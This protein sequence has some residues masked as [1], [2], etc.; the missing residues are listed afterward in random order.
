MNTRQGS[1]RAGGFRTLIAALTAAVMLTVPAAAAT[2]TADDV[3]IRNSP[4]DLGQKNSIG[5]LSSGDTVTVLEKTTDASGIE[6]YHIELPN[7]NRGYVKAQ[8]VDNGGEAVKSSEQEQAP[9]AEEAP[10]EDSQEEA[11]PAQDENAADQEAAQEPAQEEGSDDDWTAEDP[12][13]FAAQQEAQAEDGEEAAPAEETGEDQA[14]VSSDQDAPAAGSADL[15][16]PYTDPEAHYTIHFVT[17]ND[18]T[19]NWYIY[20]YDTDKRIRIGDLEQLSDARASAE[21][22]AS[23]AARW[24]TIACIL[25]ILLVVLLLI[26]Y[27]LVKRNSPVRPRRTSASARDRRR[28][29]GRALEEDSEEEDSAEEDSAEDDTADDFDEEESEES[30]SDRAVLEER[31]AS[32]DLAEEG[33]TAGIEPAASLVGKTLRTGSADRKSVV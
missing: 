14:G 24:R 12:E 11:Q 25:L 30:G 18:G 20:N 8:W 33:M 16:D 5:S 3:V 4:E 32:G 7:K 23:A 10:A 27:F 15:Y 2:V 31:E 22:N 13:M 26:L 17:E 29:A 19:G 9:A 28:R 21:K 6:W 1:R